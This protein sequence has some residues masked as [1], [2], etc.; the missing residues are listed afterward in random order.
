MGQKTHFL[1]LCWGQPSAGLNYAVKYKCANDILSPTAYHLKIRIYWRR[2]KNIRKLPIIPKLYTNFWNLISLGLF[3]S[4][5]YLW[6]Y[7]E[8]YC[9]I[10]IIVFHLSC[11]VLLT[12]IKCQQ[13]IWSVFSTH[14]S[15]SSLLFP[16]P[17]LLQQNDS[18]H[19]KTLLLQKCH[20][21]FFF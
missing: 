3:F 18:N 17:C 2:F 15:V 9:L 10:R 6:L 20:P 8:K 7:K 13:G 1:E 4:W 16:L 12:K 11:K 21:W 5:N 14:N 19:Q